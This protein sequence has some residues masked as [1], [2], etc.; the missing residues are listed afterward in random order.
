MIDEIKK[1][2]EVVLEAWSEL[3]RIAKELEAE[4]HEAPT[5]EWDTLRDTEQKAFEAWRVED[6]L[7]RKMKEEQNE[8]N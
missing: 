4:V 7:L 1:Q 3:Q 5:H 8:I 6:G 2:E